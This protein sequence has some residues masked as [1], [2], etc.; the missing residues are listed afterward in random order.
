MKLKRA[1]S[2]VVGGLGAAALGNRLLS[3][4][5]SDLHPALDG[6]QNTYRWRGFDVAYTEAGDPDDP[7]VLLLHGVHAA[8][9]NKEFDQIFEQLSKT[10]HVIAPDL[11]GFGQSD[12]PPLTYSAALYTAFVTDFAEDLTDDATVVATSL[13]GAYAALAQQQSGVFSRLV[14]IAPTADTGSRRTWVRSLI[15]VPVVGQA[16]FNL[17]TSKRSLRFFDDREGYSTEAS[18]TE[19]EVDYQWQTAHQPGARFAPAS[20]VSGYLDPDVDLGTELA[21]LDIPVTLVWG[22]DATVTPLE[23]G[24]E[25]AERADAKLVVFDD[26]KL[27]PH[28][29]HPGP[30]LEMLL[31]ELTEEMEAAA[32]KSAGAGTETEREAEG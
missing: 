14:L 24:E 16:M 25:L 21:Q 1:L 17:L 26:A 2:G 28:A 10:H 6:R 4:K 20:F 8:A 23:D 13:A 22:R 18:Y 15:R 7:D 12:R 30:F 32:D 19:R 11:P 27:L 31:D 9:S 5:A 3:W 29:E